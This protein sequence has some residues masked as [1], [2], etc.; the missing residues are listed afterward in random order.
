MFKFNPSSYVFSA[1][2]LTILVQ[3]AMQGGFLLTVLAL[4]P[5]AGWFWF[6]CIF[7]GPNGKQQTI[8]PAALA[9]SLGYLIAPTFVALGEASRFVFADLAGGDQLTWFVLRA[10]VIEELAKFSAVLVTLRMLPASARQDPRHT[11]FMALAAAL[12]FAAYE[13][14]FHGLYLLEQSA[15][16]GT[17]LFLLG[18]LI[19]VP[20]HPLYASIW[21]SA[22]AVAFSAPGSGQ[23]WLLP[24]ALAFA[25]LAHGLWDTLAQH[26]ESALAV[27]S[28]LALYVALWWMHHHRLRQLDTLEPA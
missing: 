22:L 26:T 7:T 13:N 27:L 8:W 16:K 19:R 12:G 18:A 28:L 4:L 15:T 6:F 3:A 23:R 5:A 17:Q 10:G 2:V 11:V 14:F 1:A 25:M 24:A 9:A 21:G 20:L